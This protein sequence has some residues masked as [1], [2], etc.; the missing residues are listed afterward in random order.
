MK[1][2]SRSGVTL[3]EVLVSIGIIGLLLAIL[4]PAVQ[5]ARAV[6]RRISCSSNMHQIMIACHSYVDVYQVFPTQPSSV[7]YS[8]LSSFIE[9]KGNDLHSKVLACPSDPNANGIVN[10]QRVSYYAN[11]GVY[12]LNPGDGFCGYRREL[13]IKPSSVVDGL[14]NTAAFSERLAWP[15]SDVVAQF[16]SGTLPEE[17]ARLKL[18]STSTVHKSIPAIADE[19]ELR[20]G[21][22]IIPWVETYQYNHVLP[23][24]G[25]SCV[26]DRSFL[27]PYSI[28]A[29][30]E[31]SGG[32]N[33]AKADGSV[34]FQ[35]TSIDR[36]VWWALGT[37]ARGD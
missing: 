1:N 35:S 11:N 13:Y 32:V 10:G 5:S 36:S 2:H 18:R 27:L 22:T 9:L 6:S 19:C 29:M 30:S 3:I 15:S 23:P 31:H 28:A 24:E 7:T 21:D 26:N 25:N 8:H 33:V 12:D 14:S 4:I 17:I 16:G 20:A 37:R 34:H